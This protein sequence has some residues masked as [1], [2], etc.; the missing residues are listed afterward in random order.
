MDMMNTFTEDE[1]VILKNVSIRYKW[2]A[3]D[4]SGALFVYASMPK[5][6]GVFTVTIYAIS[7]LNRSR[8]FLRK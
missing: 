2:I 1:Q 7:D 4:K 8:I 3:R 5:R 6:Q